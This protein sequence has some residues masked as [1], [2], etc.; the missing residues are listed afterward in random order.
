[1]KASFNFIRFGILALSISLSA[2][3]MSCENVL[4]IQKDPNAVTVAGEY[5]ITGTTSYTINGNVS[6]A[7]VSGTLTVYAG[8]EEDT[9]YFREKTSSYTLAY[10]VTSAGTNC[11]VEPVQESTKYENTWYFGKQSGG[12]TITNGRIQLDR[13]ANTN[14][15][16]L[17]APTGETIRYTMPI[18]KHV[19][20]EANKQPIQ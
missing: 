15:V 5:K 10:Q 9:Y 3:L 20:L 2:L 18:S 11:S 16:V 7:P 12:G 14:S 6:S 13:Y 8:E 1:M 4:T 17:N 19:H